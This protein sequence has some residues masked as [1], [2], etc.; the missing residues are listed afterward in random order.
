MPATLLTPAD[1][2]PSPRPRS[3]RVD[4]GSAR[5]SDIAPGRGSVLRVFGG[6]G[7]RVRPAPAGP[8][9]DDRR[10]EVRHAE[11]E[12]RAWVGWKGWRR[13]HMSNAL[14]VNLS[15]GG[16]L[17]FLDTPPPPGRDLW[18]YLESPAG[19]A[20]VKAR[21]VEICTTAGG[22]CTAR[23]A[24]RE[25]CPFSV[26]EAAVCGLAAVHPGTRAARGRRVPAGQAR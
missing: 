3:F 2:Q 14:V 1:P 4:R 21:A 11:V 9:A 19:K 5:G 18:V 12:C 13:F 24:F 20:V 16:A 10:A 23:V 8:A 7:G 17:V 6:W 22:Q 26:F 15:R 25:P